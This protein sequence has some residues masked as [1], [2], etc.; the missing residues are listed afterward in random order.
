LGFARMPVVF[1]D[2]GFV[3]MTMT[4]DELYGDSGMYV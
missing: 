3:V 4:G 2:A 1:R